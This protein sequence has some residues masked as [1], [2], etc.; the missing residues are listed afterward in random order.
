MGRGV[1]RVPIMLQMETVECG[2]VCLG[3]ILAHYKRYVPLERLRI[4]CGVSR[5]G[6]NARSM[7]E[8]A[9]QYGLKAAGF[10]IPFSELKTE[11]QFPCIA[12]WEY[13]HFIVIRGI[14]NGTVYI[15]DPAEGYIKMDESTFKSGFT[16][17]VLCFEPS[18]EF[19]PGGQKRSVHRYVRKRLKG[20]KKAVIFV[21]LTTVL[22]YFFE[23]VDPAM[24]S[25][26]LN[27]ILGGSNSDLLD[28]FIILLLLFA[29][30]NIVMRWTKAIYQ[31]KVDGK[32]AVMGS[33]NYMWHV[34]RLPMTFFSG[35]MAG[36]IIKRQEMNEA[37]SGTLV[38]TIGPVFFDTIMVAFYL[39]IMTQYHFYL[40]L[41]GLA[42][43]VIHTLVATLVSY[44]RV[45]ITRIQLRDESRMD[46]YMLDGIHMIETIKSGGAEN[47]FFAKWSGYQASL[48]K[49]KS[50]LAKTDVLF[51][52]IPEFLEKLVGDLVLVVGVLLV[53]KGQFQV[54]LIMSF[55]EVMELF[56]RPASTTIEAAQTIR[57]METQMERVE[58][59][60]KYAEDERVAEKDRKCEVVSGKLMGTVEMKDVT[61]G[62]SKQSQP[63]L[64]N[65]SLS[66]KQGQ[67]I[68]VV[69]ESGCGKST[70]VNLITGIYKPWSGEVLYDGHKIDDIDR[71]I[72]TGSVAVVDQDVI[73]FEDT[74][75]NNIKMWDDTIEDFEMIL[76]ARD[77]KIHDDI[78]QRDGGYQ[79]VLTEG[80]ADMSGGE[81][82]RLE[83]A[84]VLAK[85]PSVLVL[86][87]ATSA[88]DAKTEAE[89]VKAVSDRGIT[90]I[91]IA[92]RLSTIRDCDMIYCMEHGR[93]V[94][95][96]THDEL[97]EKG[98]LYAGLVMD[99]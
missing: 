31:L 28:P 72:F 66:V 67:R 3:M 58:D 61:F 84:R 51:G 94:E 64:E 35:R 10:R 60:M 87:E 38:N 79:Y 86:D 55:Q 95:S 50:K 21:A 40:G 17:V 5:D 43:V 2:A 27:D 83:I 91:V 82:Q 59:V 19:E 98:G 1:A 13:D 42:S 92:H 6:S 11:G 4:D 46:S 15:N 25:F 53:I 81:K 7:V 97:F 68:A 93:I 80:G 22:G 23:I 39:I 34:V 96:G 12:F 75:E 62:Y 9:R 69:G 14:K 89:V 48:Y 37:I 70:L 77:A 16:G 85:D 90:C 49:N 57:E 8:A 71:Y 44:K 36:D 26:F 18:E 20:M 30:M 24:T 52:M 88:L 73:L 29:V 33:M 54:G 63:L 76:A 41:L 99:E 47:G 45:E 78:L 56:L 74:I 32:M 65:F